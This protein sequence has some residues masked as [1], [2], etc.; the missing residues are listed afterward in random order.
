MQ[1]KL[2]GY[3]FLGT[4][5][6][7]LDRATKIAALAW[8]ADGVQIMNAILSFQLF[9]NRGVSWS[10]F[11]STDTIPFVLVSL[12]QLFIT[13]ALGFY[14]YHQYRHGHAILGEVCA[15]AGSLSNL[16]DRVIYHGVIDFIILSYYN[17]S[18][19]VFNIADAAIVVG[20]A[21]MIFQREVLG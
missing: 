16:I 18:W 7:S 1:K 21:I 2:C 5:I 10:L 15:I 19:P 4:L 12:L 6:F 8:C 3:L 13:V 9:F 20:V 11:H 14:A 17:F